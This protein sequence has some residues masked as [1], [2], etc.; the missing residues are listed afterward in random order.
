MAVHENS[1]F[2]SPVIGY[3][4]DAVAFFGQQAGRFVEIKYYNGALGWIDVLKIR[5]YHGLI[6]ARP[7]SFR[8]SISCSARPS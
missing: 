7:P 1:N 2:A 4:R 6:L 8:A 5:P 3:T